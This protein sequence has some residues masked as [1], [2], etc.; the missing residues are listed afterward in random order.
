[1][2]VGCS[3]LKNADTVIKS[4]SCYSKATNTMRRLVLNNDHSFKYEHNAGLASSKS[5]GT[6]SLEEDNIILKSDE[7]YKSGF[8][9]TKPSKSKTSKD[10]I[11]IKIT[12]EYDIPISDLLVAFDSSNNYSLTNE[13]GIVKFGKQGFTQIRIIFL[14]TEYVKRFPK[15]VENDITINL[16]VEDISKVYFENEIWKRK[17]NKLINPQ[18]T[19][20]KIER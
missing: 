18:G 16:V 8:L 7:S 11:S 17:G 4:Y 2:I 6:W 1:L 10:S 20:F 3:S 9:T 12:E 19:V 14:G 13:S 15:I 5:I